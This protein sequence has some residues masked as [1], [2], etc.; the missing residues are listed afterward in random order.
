MMD[1]LSIYAI[2]DIEDICGHEDMSLNNVRPQ[3]FQS[4]NSGDLAY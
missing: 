3:R 4:V 1:L 2:R